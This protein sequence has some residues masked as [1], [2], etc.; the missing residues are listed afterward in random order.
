MHSGFDNSQQLAKMGTQ[1]VN[2]A[3]AEAGRGKA[4]HTR[5]KPTGNGTAKSTQEFFLEFASFLRAANSPKERREQSRSFDARIAPSLSR[6]DGAA[7][8]QIH[9]Y[10]E[11]LSDKAE[12]KTLIAATT[13]MRAAGHPVRVWSYSPQKL[14]FLKPHGIDVGAAADVVP[15]ALFERIV[16]GS[17]IRYFSD[18]FRYAV[19]Y[20]HGGLWMDSDVIMLRPFPFRGQHFFNLQWRAGAKPEHYI[21]GNAMYAEP[22]SHHLRALY[23]ASIN[24]FFDASS[25]EFGVVGPKLLSDYIASD[26]G[27]ELQDSVFSPDA[28]QSDRL[29]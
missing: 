8:P 10:Y 15:R 19:L 24:C 11:V 6:A 22:F 3:L 28:V 27:A 2:E 4:I 5:P 18:V 25:R 26:A 7:L 17:E 12:H 23:E 16:A 20:E 13:S 29:D 9:C 1:F 21:C 14:E